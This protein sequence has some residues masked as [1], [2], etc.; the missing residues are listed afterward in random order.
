MGI[1]S[2]LD[3]VFAFENLEAVG[4]TAQ[5]HAAAVP[6][7]FAA[8]AAGA[9]LVWYGCL[10]FEGEFDAA[11]LAASFKFPRSLV[12]AVETGDGGWRMAWKAGL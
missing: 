4:D 8:D 6:A 7:Y 5:V 3:Q 10:G 2:I 9:E 11:A 1:E 12:S